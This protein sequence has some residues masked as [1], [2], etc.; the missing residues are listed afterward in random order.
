MKSL[1]ENLIELSKHEFGHHTVICLLDSVDDTVLLHKVILAELLKNAKDL[2]VNEYGRKV[3]SEPPI[4]F[5]KLNSKT[6]T[7]LTVVGCSS[8]FYSVPPTIH[9]TVNIRQGGFQ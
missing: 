7:G 5:S 4:I 6:F 1:K 9:S 8:R 2:A 3:S